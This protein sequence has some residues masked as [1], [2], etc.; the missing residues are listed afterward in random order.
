M[1]TV[2]ITITGTAG[3]DL[4]DVPTGFSSFINSPLVINALAGNDTIIGGNG[5]DTINGAGGNDS[6]DGGSGNDTIDGGSENDI[7]IGS[8]G[9]DSL[10]GG[11]GNDTLDYSSLNGAI[12]L[13]TTG[14]VSK[15]ILLGTDTVG[16]TFETIIAD[17][18]E[19]N[20]IEATALNAFG[21]SLN[22]NLGNDTLTAVGVPGGNF[23]LNVINFDN[24]VGSNQNDT[25]KGSNGSNTLS[26]A[27]GNDIIIGTSGSDSLLGGAGTDTLDYSSLGQAITLEARGI[28][29]KGGLGTDTLGD[30]FETIIGDATQINT[31]DGTAPSVTNAALNVDLGGGTLTA[32]GTPAGNLSFNVINFTNVI[33][34]NNNDTITGTTGNNTLSG[35]A[36]NDN[37]L[38]ALGDDL[39]DG[40]AGNDTLL[41][42]AGNDSIIGSSGSDS[43]LGGV[44]NDT[45]DYS[46]LNGAIT[47]EARGIVDKGGLGTDTLGDTF[48]T[49]I[50]D[51]G[52]TNTI[53]GTAPSVTNAALNVDL[54]S[55]TLTAVGTPAGDLNFNV[56][57]F[58]NVIGGNN[59]DTITG[60]TGNNTLLGAA[61]DDS[62]IGTSGNDSLLG[63]AGTDT[64]DYS[65]LGEA[66]TFGAR[67]IVNKGGMMGNDTLGDTFETI[68]GDATQ[69][70]TI[71][72]TAPSVT[73]AALNVDLGSDTLTAVGTPAGN[74]NFNV[75][76]F[77]NV[78][79]GNNNDTI[80]GNGDE[81]T[82]LGG[83]GNDTIAGAVG[84][85][86]ING[87][88]GIDRMTGGAG[89]DFFFVDSIN[90]VVIENVGEG[91]DTVSST[92][93]YSLFDT[94]TTQV[95][96]LVL[97]G[98]GNLNGTGNSLDNQITGNTGN[99]T[100]TG[101]GGTDTLTGGSGN[102]TLV[103]GTGGTSG[104]P[105]TLDGGVGTDTANYSSLNAPI[106]LKPQGIVEKG[107][108]A[109]LGV[110]E[111][112]GVEVIIGQTGQANSIDVSTA[113]SGVAIN[114]NLAGSTNNL[115]VSGPFASTFTARNFVNAIGTNGDDTIS[116]T[117]G[118]NNLAGS[119]GN[120][121]INANSG[122]DIV[123][124]GAGNDSLLGVTGN[125]SIGGDA[126]NDTLIGAAGADTLTGGTN[127][128]TF[129][130]T[131][132]TDS[133]LGSTLLD[134]ITDFNATDDLFRV[135][136]AIKSVVDVSG[137]LSFTTTSLTATAI[138]TAAVGLLAN[139]AAAFTS[140]SDPGST[141]LLLNNATA[142]FSSSADSIIKL[143][144]FTG[145]LTASDFVV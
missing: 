39:I 31:I 114:A 120:D 141:Y 91:T 78:T 103:S 61:G 49:I 119:G 138:S 87:G 18:D 24:I 38:G 130:Y 8:V 123:S 11:V 34:G 1:T 55:D 112:I 41:G 86:T 23:N 118:I 96:N 7:I 128:D 43:L 84:N 117:T 136:S 51:A 6:I 72:G 132:L 75:I 107:A 22:V 145:T 69:T 14:I 105:E 115:I 53:D 12:T 17:A 77:T 56:I 29:D 83:A 15:G 82:L 28:V 13:G 100:L 139:Q 68:I 98:T 92:V 25:I 71:D 102:D 30:T 85:D 122:D 37:V 133:R 26:G 48:E 140:A 35:A 20:T 93:T 27:G 99:N 70:N 60:S 44:G 57:N 124:G 4:I 21:G 109:F 50:G 65:S 32:V 33:G 36:G 129:V 94:S 66:I 79:G 73:N 131:T 58:R 9:N 47:L 54:G 111:L 81:N 10:L 46:S 134:V 127:N 142:S 101:N 95:E 89:N 88:I 59:N 3:N 137:V 97:T 80:T 121:I 63:G 104:T 143:Q 74:L 113:G 116:G 90:D 2:T 125:D 76:N 19:I 42:G 126:G 45:L 52:E 135:S 40:G 144:G 62:I 67:G 108:G 106:T 110:D 64:L 5:G 16:N